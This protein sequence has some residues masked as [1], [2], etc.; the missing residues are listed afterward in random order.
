MKKTWLFIVCLCLGASAFGQAD[1]EWD[2]FLNQSNSQFEQFK[3]KSDQNY[4]AFRKKIN[5]EYASFMKQHWG[6][7]DAKPMED[8]PWKPEPPKP[9]VIDPKKKPSAD[10]IPCNPPIE[11]KPIVKPQPIVPI[12]VEPQPSNKP[13]PTLRNVIMFGTTYGFSIDN[14]HTVKLNGISENEVATFWEQLNDLYFDRILAECLDYREKRQMCDWAYYLLTKNV[15]ETCCGGSTNEAVVLHMYLLTQSGFKVRIA[16]NEERM[17]ILLGSD[18]KIYRYTYYV[19]DGGIFYLMDTSLKGQRLYIFDH[20]FPKEH[21]FSL[22]QSQQDFVLNPAGKRTVT[23]RRYPSVSATVETNKNLIDFYNT[24]PLSAEWQYYSATSLSAG[25][26]KTLYPVLRE[27]IKGKSEVDA[28]NIL[29]NFV[30]TGFEY[31]TDDKQFG[32]ERP[33]FPDET[34]YYPYSDCEDRSILYA[35]LVRELMGLEAVLLHYPGHLAT[36]VR[37]KGNVSGDYL[38]VDGVK[39]IVCDPTYI[40]APIGTAMP[41]FKEVKANVVKF[42]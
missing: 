18:E 4:E 13:A 33:L 6:S 21:S 35:N 41:Q 26:K 39:Y 24:Y 2:K 11:P 22:S 27:A 15:A 5:D 3:Q 32:Y 30:Q 40:G 25:L 29:I 28:A 23:S 1:D 8:I 31:A 9:I 19:L 12:K 10:P 34:F 37:F 16:R 7:F 14:R 36:A 38:M 17:A 42:R 20:A